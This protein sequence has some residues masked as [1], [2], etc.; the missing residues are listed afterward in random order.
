VVYLQ[1][2]LLIPPSNIHW[3]ISRDVWMLKR[4]GNGN[5]WS[6]PHALLENRG[7]IDKACFSLEDG[8]VLTRLEMD[9]VPT[10]FPFPVIGADELVY[11]RKVED[12]VRRGRVKALRMTDSGNVSVEF[13]DGGDPIE[14]PS[15]YIFVHCTSP[16]PFNGRTVSSI[17]ED[18]HR[19]TL[20]ALFA[21][22]IPISFSV[23]A[24]LES[25]LRKGTLD[26]AFARKLIKESY[27]EDADSLDE[28]EVISRLVGGG[29]QLGG[30]GMKNLAEQLQPM[31]LLAL[32]FCLYDKDPMI[33]YKWIKGNR[34]SFFSIPGFKGHLYENITMITSEGHDLGFSD[35]DV[36]L[37][38]L[39]STKLEPLKGK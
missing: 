11:L 28:N 39:L 17:F 6:F 13:G 22:P 2:T 16:G 37:H 31:K 3:V 19:M 24:A 36:K 12:K 18:S 7:D 38:Q 21:P 8:N 10:R 33:A 5:P 23:L 27:G 26:L 35:E 20:N 34:L 14:L 29:Y 15:S 9:I 1:R 25:S 4:N 30:G 32:F